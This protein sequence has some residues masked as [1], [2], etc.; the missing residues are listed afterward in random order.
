M[1]ADAERPYPQGRTA[2]AAPYSF[3]YQG[4]DRLA[5][6]PAE[7]RRNETGEGLRGAAGR[8]HRPGI[9]AAIAIAIAKKEAP[10]LRG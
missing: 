10:Q 2:K 1:R 9:L 5:A 3:S 7:G 6:M 4:V 8:M